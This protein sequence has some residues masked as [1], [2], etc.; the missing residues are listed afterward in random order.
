MKIEKL[1]S[2]SYRIRKQ[3]DGK[4]YSLT[5]DHKPSQREIDNKLAERIAET[6]RIG[7]YMTLKQACDEYLKSKSNVLSPSTINGYNKILRVLPEDLLKKNV[8][9]FTGHEV[10]LFINKLALDHSPKYC[11]NTHGFIS[12]VLKTFNPQLKLTTT[13]PKKAPNEAYIPTKSD[14][15]AILKYVEGT[16]YEIPFSLAMFGLRRSEICA[17]T[18]SDLDDNTNVIHIN[19]AMVQDKNNQWHIRHMTK[20]DTS[21]RDVYIPDKLAD[22]IRERNVV[23]EGHPHSLTDYLKDIQT[24]L[25]LPRFTI[26]KF[27]HYF[28]TEMAAFADEETVMAMGGWKTDYVMKN[29]YRHAQQQRLLKAQ[30]KSVKKLSQNIWD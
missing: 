19:K 4:T 5:F 17:L 23:Y 16:R 14:I 21:V 11:R 26:H 9:D 6:P 29:V 24:R 28:A 15:K 10:Q 3:I 30:K 7:K 22:M 1:P 25:G 2:G 8:Y 12:A 13:L 18:P 27:R 20:T